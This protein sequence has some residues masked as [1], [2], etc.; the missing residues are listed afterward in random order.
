MQRSTETMSAL[1]SSLY[2]NVVAAPAD[3]PVVIDIRERCFKD[4]ELFVELLVGECPQIVSGAPTHK[5]SR[6]NGD[7]QLLAL[8]GQD[9]DHL[10]ARCVN[11]PFAA[12]IASSSQD[13]R[14][15][16]TRILLVTFFE[17]EEGSFIRDEFALDLVVLLP[18]EHQL[19]CFQEAD[20]RYSFET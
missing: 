9:I 7:S 8:V 12:R 10:C 11:D 17:G 3:A 5:Q 19:S 18:G 13:T 2:G 16:P 15:Q 14:G 4:R 6:W 20:T 1:P